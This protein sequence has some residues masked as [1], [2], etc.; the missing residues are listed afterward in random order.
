MWVKIPLSQ[1]SFSTNKLIKR[2]VSYTWNGQCR[3]CYYTEPVIKKV[4]VCDLDLPSQ[5][6]NWN[7]T[8]MV[9]KMHWMLGY[10]SGVWTCV[11]VEAIPGHRLQPPEAVIPLSSPTVMRGPR[12]E[13]GPPSPSP[14]LW[15]GQ[16]S[17]PQ[18]LKLFRTHL[19]LTYAQETNESCWGVFLADFQAWLLAFCHFFQAWLTQYKIEGFSAILQREGVSFLPSHSEISNCITSIWMEVGDARRWDQYTVRRK[20]EAEKAV[21]AVH[22]S[23]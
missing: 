14:S 23:G 20:A 18:L 8:T 11:G 13:R 3:Y 5:D 7:V 6:L 15:F 9:F 2:D 17:K 19:P 22:G 1:H 21:D 12:A 10:K 16:G 4:Y